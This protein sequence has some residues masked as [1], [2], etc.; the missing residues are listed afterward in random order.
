M[1]AES[2]IGA[3]VS[4]AAPAAGVESRWLRKLVALAVLAPLAVAAAEVF[5]FGDL[6]GFPIDDSWI[7]LQFA[8]NLHAGAGLSYGGDRLVA[9]ST[10]P[11][12][13]AL[14]SAL[15]ALPGAVELWTKLLGVALHAVSVVLTFRLGRQLGLAPSRSALAAALVA[16]TDVLVWSA[17]SGMEVPLFVALSLAGLSRHVAERRDPAMSPRSFLLFGLAALA[18]PEGLLL[19]ILAAVDRAFTSAPDASGPAFSPIGARRALAG[20]ALAAMVVVPVALAFLAI[21]GSPLPTTLGAKSSGPPQWIPQLR[22]L[23]VIFGFIFSS[24]PLPALLA[25]GGAARLVGRLGGPRDSG[26]LLPAWALSMPVAS[27]MLSSGQELLVGNFGRYFFPLIPPFIVLGV[28]AL[29]GVRFDRLRN[30]AIGRLRIPLA[31]GALLAAMILPAVA[32]TVR[33]G[34]LYLRARGNV[35]D[36]DSAAAAWI[37]RFVPP[38]AKLALCDVGVVGYRRPNPIVDLG[39]IVS[40]ERQRYLR[41][42]KRERGLAWPAAL[43]LWLDEQRPEIVVVFP[44][45]FPLLEHEP[46]RFP[47]LH[48]FRIA[49]NVAMAGDELVIYGTPW[50]RPGIFSA[51]ATLPP[52]AAP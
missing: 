6:R 45:W 19:P 5:L 49:D 13:T 51:V 23:R 18:R 14:L 10:S 35:E 24:Q 36:S 41:T 33:G 11:L 34:E 43:R 38:D 25:A 20:L 40:P 17:I 8:R 52:P 1:S 4:V 47:V 27:S 15:Y 39:G 44:S 29:E 12:W 28:V 21:S 31:V 16:L 9:A 3:K 46:S 22:H 2:R 50:T 37:G 7:H 42:M 32:L 30:L 48:R 26:L